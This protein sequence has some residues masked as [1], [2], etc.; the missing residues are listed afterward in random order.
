MRRAVCTIATIWLASA[1]AMCGGNPFIL[2]SID[3]GPGGTDADQDAG[4]FDATQPVDAADSGLE[5]HLEP[6]DSAKPRDA[7]E[8]RGK[9]DA[10][11][12]DDGGLQDGDQGD[13]AG[14]HDA[15][16]GGVQHDASS[17]H[18]AGSVHDADATPSNG[19]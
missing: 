18:D 16:D 7:S 15:G 4:A 10:G 9:D 5:D 2:D 1:L 3:E 8:D 11:Q 12:I 17:V 13:G 19:N 14:A 6:S